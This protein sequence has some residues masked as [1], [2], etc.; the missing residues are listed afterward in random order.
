MRNWVF[1]QSNVDVHDRIAAM[2]GDYEDGSRTMEFLIAAGGLILLLGALFFVYRQFTLRIAAKAQGRANDEHNPWIA[3]PRSP[4]ELR[5][6][7]LQWLGEVEKA[8]V[9]WVFWDEGGK[10]R[11]ARVRLKK[12]KETTVFLD[13]REGTPPT[14]EAR[15]V[16]PGQ[17]RR[18]VQFEMRARASDRPGQL[19]LE[20]RAGEAAVE[21]GESARARTG[22]KA[23]AA[24]L[25]GTEGDGKPFALRVIDMSQ[26]GLGIICDRLLDA[27]ARYRIKIALH[28]RAE[29][30]A[31]DTHVA[32]SEEG[33][34]GIHRGGLIIDSH[35][36]EQDALIS[37]FLREEARRGPAGGSEA[38]A[39]E[40][41]A[42]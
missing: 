1:L 31:F 10:R 24:A 14:G 36:F 16:T 29:K 7:L 34:G 5:K 27:D 18:G 4:S 21:I 8:A 26:S 39:F 3:K 30:L 17:G 23:A 2:R 9:C 40:E 28:D 35:D 25:E 20:A 13:F 38:E 15:L 11:R 37:D 33:S 6:E 32:W 41:P 19:V 42:A 12:V 22:L